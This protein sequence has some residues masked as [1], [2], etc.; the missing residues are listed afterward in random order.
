MNANILSSFLPNDKVGNWETF[1]KKKIQVNSEYM[2]NLEGL[3][4]KLCQL[5]EE[6][7]DDERVLLLRSAALEVLAFM[8]NSFF[9]ALYLFCWY[10]YS[11][12]ILIS[13]VFPY[14]MT[15]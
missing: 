7:G 13:N 11:M 6:V 4:P 12:K 5:A 8:V 9:S 1:N 15:S 10:L 3:I 2:F 14:N